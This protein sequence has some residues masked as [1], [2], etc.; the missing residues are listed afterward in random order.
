MVE[1][2][3]LWDF[4]NEDMSQSQHA[5]FLDYTYLIARLFDARVKS[6]IEN[7][8]LGRGEGKIS[9]YQ[10]SYRVEFQARGLP[11]IH[12]ICWITKKELS[13]RGIEGDL[14]DNE[15]AALKLADELISCALPEDQHNLRDIVSEVQRHKHTKSCLKYDGVCR[16]GFPKLP[17]PRT[18]LS[19]PLELS[20]PKLNEKERNT[21]K[22][23]ASKI[24]S[25]AKKLLIDIDEKER[26]RKKY[27]ASK[28]LSDA[29]KLLMDTN[30]D[31]N[32]TLEEFYAAIN[33]NENDYVEALSI[34]ERGRVLIL[35]RGLKERNVNNYNNE[36]ILAW[37]ANMDIQL[38]VDP[39]A[40]ISY[41]ASYMN[42]DEKQTTP[43]LREAL[44]ASAGKEAREKLK[45]LKEAYI[46]HRQVGASEAAYKVN[47]GLKMKDS[48]IACIF[49]VTGF[50]KNRSTFYRK[51]KDTVEEEIGEDFEGDE[52]ESEDEMEEEELPTSK[53]VKIEGRQGTYKESITVIDRYKAR[54]DHLETM[55]LAQFATAYVFAKKVPKKVIFD[56]EG[57]SDIFSNT[58]IFEDCLQ[59]DESDESWAMLQ[60]DEQHS[61]MRD[62]E[63]NE[64]YCEPNVRNFLP[65]YISLKDNLGKMRLRAYPA[66]M[67]IHNSRKKDGHEQQ[68]SELLLFSPW[69]DEE[70]EFHAGNEKECIE[71]FNKRLEKIKKNKDMIYP[72]EGTLDL[73]ENVDHDIQAPAHIYDMLDG[74]GQQQQ[75]DDLADGQENDPQFESFGYT[76]NLAQGEHV[77]YESSKYR[78]VT[79]PKDHELKLKTKRLVPEQINILRK[80]VEYCRDV[81]KF[82]KKLRHPVKP[83]KLIVHGGGGKNLV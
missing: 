42:K 63:E 72:G 29:E 73:L 13:E 69:R 77:P 26:I 49:V 43:F 39:Y 58:K 17:S 78:V 25:D 62:N 24:L 28:T 68:Y 47:P 30:S 37:N 48:N 46:G 55:C 60:E 53:V 9:I 35:K 1:G 21:K 56:E 33:T 54:P 31:E 15:E 71:E 10:Y 67:R 41:I 7:I 8:L 70:K 45:A 44:H 64:N 20:H 65:K 14:M 82:R 19:K 27:K 74:E 3:E 36:M 52:S 66:V 79:V 76:G 38:V 75:E 32:M 18:V 4:V 51:V 22:A 11:H 40:V 50:P 57:C 12:G 83:L 61:S 2:R 6:F 34:S 80:V 16:Y 5:L 59:Q 81:V 23:K